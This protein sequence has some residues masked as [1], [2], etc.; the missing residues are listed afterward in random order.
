MQV[1]SRLY[2]QT[3]YL[4]IAGELDEHSANWA[5]INL[6]EQMSMDNCKQIVIDLSELEFMDSTGIGVL[7]GRY[8]KMKQRGI[9]I[10]ISNPSKH[11]DRIFR[12]SALY[13]VMPKID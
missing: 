9:P 4:T 1:N 12:M 6:D 11:I 3:L 2:Q 10:Y 7:L 5:R 13:D 8:K